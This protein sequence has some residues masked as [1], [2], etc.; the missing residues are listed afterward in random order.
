ELVL[1]LRVSMLRRVRR[2]RG[3]GL[4]WRRA[5][6]LR[7]PEQVLEQVLRLAR[8]RI[9]RRLAV[10]V[11]RGLGR[12]LRGSELLHQRLVRG[13]PRVGLEF[14]ALLRERIGYQALMQ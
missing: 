8:E 11:E 2:R 3:R 14:L 13:L 5:R 12:I 6:R 9:P 7:L 10:Q 1:G 4:G